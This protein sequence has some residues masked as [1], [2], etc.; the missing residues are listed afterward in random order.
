MEH[1]RFDGGFSL[2]VALDMAYFEDI[3]A[4]YVEPPEATV[5]TDEDSGNGNSRGTIDN[6]SWRQLRAQAE[7]RFVNRENMTAVPD[8]PTSSKIASTSFHY[9]SAERK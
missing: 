4:I 6:L 2:Q 1:I 8:L 7:V 5:L 3:D 9:S